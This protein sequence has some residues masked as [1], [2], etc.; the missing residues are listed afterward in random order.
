MR[1]QQILSVVSAV[2]AARSSAF[3]LGLGI[4]AMGLEAVQGFAGYGPLLA[5]LNSVK[6]AFLDEHENP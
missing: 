4:T 1:A 5:V 3:D 2:P 6:S